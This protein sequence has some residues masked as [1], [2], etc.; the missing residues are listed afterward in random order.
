MHVTA[1]EPAERDLHN[2]RVTATATNAACHRSRARLQHAKRR[3]WLLGL[4]SAVFSLTASACTPVGEV[5]KQSAQERAGSDAEPIGRKPTLDDD[6]TGGDDAPSNPSGRAGA[7]ARAGAGGRERGSAG[8]G[9]KSDAQT[10]AGRAAVGGNHADAGRG[11]A[12]RASSAAAGSSNE[13]GTGGKAGSAGSSSSSTG[14]GGADAAGSAASS[15]WLCMSFGPSCTCVE[16]PGVGGDDCAKPKPTCCFTLMRFGA[17]ACTCW[18]EDSEECRTQTTEVP[19]AKPA[20]EC[21]P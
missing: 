18:P 11:G 1:I 21:P 13:T 4:A 6:A 2:T 7:S 12:G 17:N 19:D 10:S 3:A 8:T 15:D 20:A 9:S 5:N 16:S 14:S